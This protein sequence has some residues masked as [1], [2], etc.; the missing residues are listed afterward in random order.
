MFR[1]PGVNNAAGAVSPEPKMQKFVRHLTIPCLACFGLVSPAAQAPSPARKNFTYEQVFGVGERGRGMGAESELMAGL[2]EVVGWLDDGTYLENRVDPT[3]KKSRLYAVDATG[4]MAKVYRDYAEMNKALPPGCDSSRPAAESVDRVRYVLDSKDDLYY[5]NYDTK[6]VH[7]LTAN[8]AREQNPRFSPDGGWVAYTRNGN[9]FAYD[10]QNLVEHQYTTDGSDTV[11]NGY[12]SWVYYEEILER[13]SNYAAFWWSPDS[14]KLAFMRF[15]DSPVPVFPIYHA[16]G[17]HGELEKQRYP[18][19]GDPNPHVSMGVVGVAE[20][21]I[22]W[23]DFEARADHYIAWPFWTA[24]SRALVVQ[25]MNRGQD[26]IRLFSCDPAS[27]KKQQVLEQQQPSWVTFFEDLYFLK[28]GSAFLVRSD[29]DGWNHLYLYGLDGSLKRQLTTGGWPVDSIEAVDEAGGYVYFTGHPGKPWDTQLM[30]VRMDG[31]GLEQLTQGDG[32]HRVRISPRGTYFIDTVSTLNA[33][34]TMSLFRSGGSV[35]RKL[36]DARKP[37][38][39][40]YALGKAELFIIPSGDGFDLPAYWLLPADF[41]P[42]RRYPVIFSIYGGPDAGTVQNSW[43]GLRPHYWAQKGVITVSVDHRGGGG[44][45]K[46]GTALMH[47]NLGKWEMTDL[48]TAAGWLRSKPFIASDKVGITGASYGGYA[49]L[50][51]LTRGADC[52]DFGQAGSAV[53]DWKLYDSVYTER[54][55]D[56]P[57]ENQEGYKNGAVLT[58][59]DRYKGL[60]RITHGDIDD[61]VHMQNSTQVVEWLTSHDKRFELMIYPDSRHGINASERPHYMRESHDFWMRNLLGIDPAAS[62]SK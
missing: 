49:T 32:T 23:M 20:G 62:K 42:S 61:N 45:G 34:A 16:D 12:A 2:P 24:D 56:K 29:V 50:M 33:P 51:A 35:I 9:L 36:G 47:R 27:G 53:T 37:A 52:F 40:E 21:R 25:W 60:L 5:F 54:Y 8:P 31:T 11:Y 14:T 55:M 43:L 17:Q 39:D 19:A 58:W 13:A 10:L 7:R 59:I 22:S 28:N 38:L 48:C 46:K 41:D 57:D 15:D 18:K 26:T 30:R 4:G 1:A 3:D 44:F 6:V